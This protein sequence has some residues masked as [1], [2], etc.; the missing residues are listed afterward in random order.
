MTATFGKPFCSLDVVRAHVTLVYFKNT[1]TASP[2]VQTDFE[3]QLT[4]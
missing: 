1:K 4:C 3:V 2:T